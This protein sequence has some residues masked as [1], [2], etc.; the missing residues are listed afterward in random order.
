MKVNDNHFN[1]KD[2]FKELFIDTMK[3]LEKFDKIQLVSPKEVEDLLNWRDKNKDLVRNHNFPLEQGVIESI[4]NGINIIF[5]KQDDCVYLDMV[6]KRNG[7]FSHFLTFF[8]YYKKMQVQTIH[9]SEDLLKENN[10]FYSEQTQSIITVFASLM[11]YME[12]NK[13]H[14]ELVNRK[15]IQSNKV[16]KNKN[17]KKKNIR[18]ANKVIYNVSFI[19]EI[20][21]NKR[22]Y[23][24][25]ETKSWTVRGH[26]RNMKDGKQI[27][28][29]P[30]KKG[31]I[32]EESN[33]ATYRI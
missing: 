12:H 8:W 32:E 16:K 27:W 23:T 25:D 5:H 28:I 18:K 20:K 29:K 30:Y 21:E 22:E 10:D 11:A 1:P 19:K 15:T 33:P 31:N 26:W 24:L 2:K 17:G 9:P 4:F 7:Q 13:E 3:P 6:M 14:K